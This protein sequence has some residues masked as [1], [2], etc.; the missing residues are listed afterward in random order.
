MYNML[1]ISLHECAKLKHIYLLRRTPQNKK[2][3]IRQSDTV[4]RLK[5]KD[6]VAINVLSEVRQNR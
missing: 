6:I 2:D 3:R 4:P 1:E 5:E